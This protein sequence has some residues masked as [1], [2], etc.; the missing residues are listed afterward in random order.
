LWINS[1]G[2]EPFVNNLFEDLRD[3][4]VILKVMDIV[5]PGIVDWS[6]V[7]LK[8]PLNKFKK[9]ENCNYAV[10]LG[11]QMKFSLVGVG[12]SDIVDGNQT[13][14][15]ALV[16]QL[17]RCHVLSIL[18]GLGSNVD[19]AAMIKWSNDRVAASGKSTKMSNFKDP[20]LKTSH[21]F[22]DLLNT[23]R[24]CVNYDLVTPGETDEDGLQNA[25]YTI[26]IARKLGCTIFL[27]P[28]DIVEVKP[29]MILTL[30][31]SIMS[32]ALKETQ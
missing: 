19:D 18:K 25:K 16:W 15:L 22:L 6:K 32:V 14:T 3:G 26:S 4:I 23:I 5:R 24:K 21:F 11:K 27:L 31:G 1:L 12:G 8:E 29:K 20:T 30:V 17:M 7:N 9:A 2:I 13:L 10:V 28:E